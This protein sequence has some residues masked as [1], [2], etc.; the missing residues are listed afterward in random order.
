MSFSAEGT[1]GT[2]SH[3]IEDISR[4]SPCNVCDIVG[5]SGDNGNSADSTESPVGAAFVVPEQSFVSA[6]ETSSCAGFLGDVRKQD[7]SCRFLAINHRPIPVKA[8]FFKNEKA[9]PFR[10]TVL[11][12]TQA[13]FSRAP[14]KIPFDGGAAIV[15]KDAKNQ[16]MLDAPNAQMLM[17]PFEKAGA[18]GNKGP[19]VEKQGFSVAAGDSFIF[20]LSAQDFMSKKQMGA[21]K[22]SLPG[23]LP[24]DL[25]EDVVEI[26]EMTVLDILA[27]TKNSDSAAKGSAWRLLQIRLKP[28]FS[29]Y[30][31]MRAMS[32]FPSSLATARKNALARQALYPSYRNDI[33]TKEVAFVVEVA[34]DAVVCDDLLHTKGLL[35]IAGWR[36][37]IENP[38]ASDAEG[39]LQVEAEGNMRIDLP[40]QVVL[41]HTNARDTSFAATLLQIAINMG[42]LRLLV[43]Q[44]DFWANDLHASHY[45]AVPLLDT[46]QMFGC[47]RFSSSASLDRPGRCNVLESALDGTPSKVEYEFDTRS[48]HVDETGIV[49]DIIL[50]VVW[51]KG[52][53]MQC[54]AELPV[55]TDD[56]IL[57][58]RCFASEKFIPVSFVFRSRGSDVLMLNAAFRMDR[59]DTQGLGSGVFKRAR[60]GC[61]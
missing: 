56:F 8:S 41:R 11:L 5:N 1:D 4:N 31:L 49:H 38:V 14:Y 59:I 35:S 50:R 46:V 60:L 53:F 51:S 29:C 48:S 52:S 18:P 13:G 37:A 40:L 36:K 6:L 20:F 25:P 23:L 55:L 26:P 21:Q 16:F 19:I 27:T 54:D 39:G 2:D 34:R 22:G 15:P 42:C 44:S 12:P 58:Q 57:C 3:M 24:D 32:Y 28:G 17:W 30:S 47:V 7:K 45:R 10:I 33:E 43:F 61:V 9:V